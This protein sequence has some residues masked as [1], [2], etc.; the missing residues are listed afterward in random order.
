MFSRETVIFTRYN[1]VRLGKLA[2]TLDDNFVKRNVV[3]FKNDFVGLGI[4]NGMLLQCEFKSFSHSFSAQAWIKCFQIWCQMCNRDLCSSVPGFSAW[5]SFLISRSTIYWQLSWQNFVWAIADGLQ[6]KYTNAV[7][8]K[9]LVQADCTKSNGMF[10]ISTFNKLFRV[11]R[12]LKLSKTET[13][14]FIT[15]LVDIDYIQKIIT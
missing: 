1:S 2:A 15:F 8:R 3:Q 9:M 7:M 14:L 5:R 4:G 12:Y 11:N 6:D 10:V 13:L